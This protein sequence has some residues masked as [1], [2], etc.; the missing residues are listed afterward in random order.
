M[1][2]LSVLSLATSVVALQLLATGASAGERSICV[3][4]KGVVKIAQGEAKCVTDAQGNQTDLTHGDM[5]AWFAELPEID[6]VADCA[7][8]AVA[9]DVRTCDARSGVPEQHRGRPAA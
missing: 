8:R 1:R 7:T 6:G 4:E 9:V 3:V 5:L 2:R